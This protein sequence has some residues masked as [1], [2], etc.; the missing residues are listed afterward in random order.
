MPVVAITTLVI[1]ALIVAALAFY[2]IWVAIVLVS[3]NRSL[4]ATLDNLRAVADR[5]R[6]L[7]DVLSDVNATLSAVGDAVDGLVERASPRAK[8][9]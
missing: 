6:P 2:L 7:G 8:A 1:V 3:V 5:T 9:S 4:G